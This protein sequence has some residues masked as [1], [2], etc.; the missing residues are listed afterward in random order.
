MNAQQAHELVAAACEEG[1]KSAR[2]AQFISECVSLSDIETCKLE[3][4]Q[5]A[6][7]AELEDRDVDKKW[8]QFLHA[9]RM[10]HEH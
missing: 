5:A 10:N 2:A 6:V 9:H 7:A 4:I 1:H 8:K 3:S